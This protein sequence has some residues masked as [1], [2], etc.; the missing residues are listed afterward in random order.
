MG[1]ECLLGGGRGGQCVLGTSEDAEEAVL[2][3]A[4][5]VPGVLRPHTAQQLLHLGQQLGVAL[6]ALL[7]EQ[8]GGA[9]DVGEEEGDGAVWEI[10][11]DRR[12]PIVGGERVVAVIAR[13]RLLGRGGSQPGSGRG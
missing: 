3:R 1:G 8:A 12:M 4:Q 13:A 5:L 10:H 6:S 9:L 11:G 2:L 7:L